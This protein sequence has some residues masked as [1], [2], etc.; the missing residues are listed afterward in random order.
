M[1]KLLHA[2]MS[3][4]FRSKPFF[5]G[6]IG[7][8]LF[9]FVFI[10]LN[11]PEKQFSSIPEGGALMLLPF[12]IGA[13]MSL[14][15][16]AEFT[17]GAIRNKLIVGHSRLNILLSWSF[18]SVLIAVLYYAAYEAS[19]FVS[20]L[21]FSYDL[22]LLQTA[23][24]VQNLLLVLILLLS[25]LFL[26]LLI[27]VI[28]EDMRGVAVMFLLQFSLMFLSTIGGEAL[29]D[30]ETAQFVFRFFPQGQLTALNILKAPDQ[31]VLTAACALSA[32]A[33]L[34]ILSAVYFRKHDMK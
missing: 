13:V 15:I 30:N 17:G 19:A 33:V 7:S 4:F 24:I 29:S 8:A 22:S 3:R 34:L 18:C 1:R 21:L 14:N 20:A 26:S 25:N 5:Y 16:A 23:D 32:G 2:D 9:A 28:V 6:L 31:P 10:L 12:F 27:C 11:A